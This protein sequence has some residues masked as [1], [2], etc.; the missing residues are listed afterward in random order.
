MSDVLSTESVWCATDAPN[1]Q[2]IQYIRLRDDNI[3]VLQDLITSGF[4]HCYCGEILTP[5]EIIELCSRYYILSTDYVL[6]TWNITLESLKDAVTP[7]IVQFKHKL[8]IYTIKITEDIYSYNTLKLEIYKEKWERQ[9]IRQN[10]YFEFYCPQF[11][12]SKYIDM[13]PNIKSYDIKSSIS[14]DN[15]TSKQLTIG[16]MLNFV[17]LYTKNIFFEE[18]GMEHVLNLKYEDWT[19]EQLIKSAVK[20]YGNLLQSMDHKDYEL[21]FWDVDNGKVDR[22]LPALMPHHTLDM[23]LESYEKMV[24]CYAPSNEIVETTQLFSV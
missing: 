6:A 13:T 15:D 18:L 2:H 23:V 24:I 22:S 19:V 3:D 14:Y 7:L 21:R 12:G 11:N 9:R 5:R 8:R 1:Y 20:L 16:C 17:P 4:V 10:S